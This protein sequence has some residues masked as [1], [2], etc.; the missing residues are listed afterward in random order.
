MTCKSQGQDL[1]IFSCVTW[2]KPAVELIG[3]GHSYGQEFKKI[4][5]EISYLLLL[6]VVFKVIYVVL[7]KEL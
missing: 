5:S 1:E 4:P 6:R 3:T 7:Q 2:R